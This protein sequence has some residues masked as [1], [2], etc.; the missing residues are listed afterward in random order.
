[1]RELIKREEEMGVRGGE[2]MEDVKEEGV[3]R[4]NRR[5]EFQSSRLVCG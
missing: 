2:V 3:R 4:R 5:K 1:M